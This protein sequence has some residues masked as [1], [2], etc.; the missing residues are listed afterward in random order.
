M[1]GAGGRGGKGTAGSPLQEAVEAFEAVSGLR[2]CANFAPGFFPPNW[3]HPLD[4][5]HRSHTS[6]FCQIVKA[7]KVMK[8]C[9]GHDS[10]R[11]A[12]RVRELRRPLV[13]VC[14]AGIV[15]V[16]VPVFV[17]GSP[18]ATFFCGQA[19]TERVEAAGFAE[20]RRRVEPL[21]VDVRALEPAFAAL[22]TVAERRME[23]VGSLLS[24]VVHYHVEALD[25]E[26]RAKRD[27]LRGY[28]YLERA[29]AYARE[30]CCE[31]ISAAEVARACGVS[32]AHLSRSFRKAMGMTFS[33]YRAGLRIAE[34]QRL[35]VRT[36]MSVMEVALRVGFSRHSYFSRC[37]RRALGVTPL[38]FRRRV[39]REN[40]QSP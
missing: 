7:N 14:H 35:L 34:A 2:V 31:E 36:S 17:D 11:L 1:T 32:P 29:A 25:R 37:F 15:E 3:P 39:L 40:R 18:V 9:G 33:E 23:H 19:R 21:G 22:P 4:W 27:R 38:D 24:A 12:A 8:H 5:A 28:P 30:H 26:V 16:A 13:N 6:E 10:E 20:V